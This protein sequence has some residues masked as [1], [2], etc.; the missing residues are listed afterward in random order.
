VK[1]RLASLVVMLVLVASLSI[2]TVAPAA[3]APDSP[4]EGT[5]YFPWVPNN[6]SLAGIAG[7]SGA[8]TV[9]NVEP[10]PVKVTV[11]DAAGNELTSLTLNPRA[12]QSWTAGELGIAEPGAGVVAVA[13]WADVAALERAGVCVEVASASPTRGTPNTVD[14]NVITGLAAR[15]DYI[16]VTQGGLTFAEAHDYTWTYADGAVAIDWSP[17]GAEPAGT[18][19]VTAYDCPTPRIAG[20]EKHTV[21][22]TGVQTSAD[23]A[24]VDGYTALP[25]ADIADAGNGGAL[26]DGQSRWIVPIAQT[27]AG[28]NTALVITNVSGK[29][30]SVNATFYA[31]GGQGYAGPSV[32]LLAGRMLKP[33]ESVTVDLRQDAGF[34]EGEV[35]SVWVDAT[36]AVVAA[37]FRMKP[38]TGMMLTTVAQPRTGGAAATVTFGPLVFRDYNGWNTGINIANLSDRDN[39]VTVTYYNYAGNVVASDTVTI[40]ARAMEY[41][42]TPASENFGIGENQITAVRIAGTAPLAAAVDEVKYLG[43]QGQEHAMSYPAGQAQMGGAS[44]TLDNGRVLYESQL[45]LPLLQKGN[46]QTGS[47]D[48][49]G[50]N[51]FNPSGM[52]VTAS[53]QFVDA[54]G[55]PVA[56]TTGADDGEAPLNL[57]LPAGAGATVYTLSLGE[58]PGGFR[59]AA[60]VGVLGGGTLVGVSNNV[61][62]EVAGDGSAVYNLLR[63]DFTRFQAGLSVDATSATPTAR[64]TYTLHVTALNAFGPI[65]GFPL[66]C[67]VSA[68]PNAGAPAIQTTTDQNGRASCAITDTAAS[69]SNH[70]DTVTVWADFNGNGVRDLTE[71]TAVTLIWQP[72]GPTILTATPS[73]T[74]PTARQSV[75]LTITAVDGYGGPANGVAVTC[76]VTSGPNSGQSTGATIG[77]D[78]QTTC[79]ITD[80]KAAANN[81]TDTITVTADVDG[82]GTGETTSVTVTW[83]PSGVARLPVSPTSSSLAYT[84]WFNMTVT[85]VDAYGGPVSGVP[86]KCQITAGPNTGQ[87]VNAT[88][89]ANGSTT[90]SVKNYDNATYDNYVDTV[91]VTG[92]VDGDGTDETATAT[93]TWLPGQSSI[94]LSGQPSKYSNSVS[95][96]FI[97][98]DGYY[99]L[100]PDLPVTCEVIQGT[101]AGKT[102][103]TTTSINGLAYC[104]F[105]G[106]TPSGTDVIVAKATIRGQERQ[107]SWIYVYW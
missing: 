46:A 5:I 84:F 30:T 8:I 21:G 98:R 45:A 53:V 9:Q 68:G 6:A 85:A 80:A 105:S 87:W 92:D 23:T 58:M 106:M 22:T 49:S 78:G 95:V 54:A 39:R 75:T 18:Y 69:G 70:E 101:N 57:T 19:T 83:Q 43:G 73:T 12:S 88:T 10:F 37:A 4:G 44:R 93:V 59:G 50:I 76:A 81:D 74:T 82:D 67:K 62:Y 17:R 1:H 36:H 100:I 26:L 77:A 51:L 29:N 40:P 97:V 90:C 79:A 42:Y 47:G 31:A 102:V 33:G 7:I 13:A 2:G 60:V 64:G 56:P 86:V 16:R 14:G 25:A 63:T 38:A 71:T 107:S 65:A 41:V 96:A 11:K 27:N 55:V 89:G 35:G 91:T 103:T 72:S 61:N 99:Q 94:N 52:A 20:V 15:P 24:M 34:P 3:A 48:T 66:E 104:S 32:A 28:W